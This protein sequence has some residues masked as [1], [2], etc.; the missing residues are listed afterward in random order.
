[1]RLTKQ[2]KA[3]LE[4]V[5]AA[6]EMTATDLLR[7]YIQQTAQHLGIAVEVGA[8]TS[9]AGEKILLDSSMPKGGGEALGREEVSRS[10]SPSSAQLESA[11]EQGAV[12]G[13]RAA[14]YRSTFADRGEGTRR[15]LEEALR[16][17]TI[18]RKEEGALLPAD[19][20]L[21]ALSSQK[22]ASLREQVRV[23][24]LRLSRKNLYLTYLRMLLHFAFKRGE[25]AVDA[26]PGAELRAITA[27]E[28]EEPWCKTASEVPP[29]P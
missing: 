8:D 11:A 9:D 21:S 3:L 14:R 4:R 16:F 19:L 15:E 7:D 18:S 20:P 1:M 6:L 12:F 27:L 26:T 29:A 5:A 25:I 23:I 2:Q 10:L 17:F 22:L 13:A 24:P 28:V